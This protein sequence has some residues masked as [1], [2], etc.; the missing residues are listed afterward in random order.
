MD[1]S[2]F[3]FLHACSGLQ[4]RSIDLP[5]SRGDCDVW[6]EAVRE[7]VY[8]LCIQKDGSSALY[9]TE[10]TYVENWVLLLEADREQLMSG[11]VSHQ[12]HLYAIMS[13]KPVQ[14]KLI[15]Q[16]V[17]LRVEAKRAFWE[18]VENSDVPIINGSFEGNICSSGS[19]IVLF[20][21]VPG[22]DPSS[23]A[24]SILE[25]S[26]TEKNWVH[27]WTTPQIPEQILPLSV[28][29]L[30]GRLHIPADTS[31]I[32]SIS[33]HRPRMGG[34]RNHSSYPFP[35][36]VLARPTDIPLLLEE[37]ANVSILFLMSTATV[38]SFLTGVC[39]SGWAYRH[40]K[41]QR[42]L[43]V[44]SLRVIG[45]LRWPVINPQARQ[46]KF[47]T[48]GCEKC[49]HSS[50]SLTGQVSSYATVQL[51]ESS[52][53][54][55]EQLPFDLSVSLSDCLPPLSLVCAKSSNNLSCL[56][57]PAA[58]VPIVH[59]AVMSEDVDQSLSN[60]QISGDNLS[61]F[62]PVTMF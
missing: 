48:F 55:E 43:A 32:F 19:S 9:C 62:G 38:C 52:S 13:S 17:V 49:L 53:W 30:N 12:D 1:V 7:A 58:F 42:A 50:W 36:V 33:L 14:G 5:A 57:L 26:T 59:N 25:Y 35:C 39:R 41:S 45:S 8:V 22:T 34:R 40:S 60:S 20:G 11:I 15:T 47:L 37:F 10:N 29:F 56:F 24:P 54:A 3:S 46:L 21:M 18:P 61:G 27:C 28:F 31:H 6:F 16:L 51:V 2:W 4:W 44:R 23:L